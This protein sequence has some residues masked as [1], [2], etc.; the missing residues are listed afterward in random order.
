M[1]R[2]A[3]AALV[4]LAGTSAALADVQ[5]LFGG[6]LKPLAG[7]DQFVAPVTSPY[8]NE[9]SMISTD[10]RG[11]YVYHKFNSEALGADT[12]AVDYA[13]QVRIALT[14]SLQLVAYKDGFLDFDGAVSSEGWN[15]LA[16]GI[17]WQ[18][19]RD[20]ENHLF[21]AAGAGYEFKTGE[22]DALQN[23]S[24]MR[25]WVSV[26]KG[27]G[28]FHAGATLNYRIATSGED[29]DNGN[30]D[31]LTWHLR[32]DY[33]LTDVFSPV[34]ELN[35]YHIIN[36]SDTGV[37]LNGA[38]VLNLGATDADDTITVGLGCEFRC[39]NNTALRA[40]YELPLTDNDSDLFGTRLTFSIVYTF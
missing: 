36:D 33:R 23:D 15:D 37:A 7:D 22:S 12:N 11:W 10:V 30:S 24:E 13:V 20:D 6:T 8:Y 3:L 32:G 19:L 16:A 2:I 28:K 27:F 26:D 35:G 9:N 38:D 17:K 4:A 34:I 5:P 25:L 18:F 39:G 14:D 1:N 31:V 21:A 40:A 29:D